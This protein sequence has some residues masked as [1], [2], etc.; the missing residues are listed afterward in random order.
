MSTASDHP[1]PEGSLPQSQPVAADED[2]STKQVTPIGRLT[3]A[4]VA[5]ELSLAMGLMVPLQLVLALHLTRLAD[6]ADATGAFGIVT[7]F[8]ALMGMIANPI[9]GWLSDRSKSRLGRRRTWIMTGALTGALAVVAV[10]F[11]TEV[12]Q[13]VVVWCCVTSLFNFQ[14][15]ATV[16]LLA[17]QVPPKRRGGVS[18]ILGVTMAGGPLIGIVIANTMTAGSPQQWQVLALATIVLAVVAVLLIREKASV[19]SAQAAGGSGGLLAVVKSFWIS[20]RRHPAYW[21]AWLVRFLLTCAIAAPSF[22]AF[23]L[24][25]RFGYSPDEVGGMILQLSGAMIV[26]M[27]ISAIGCGFISDAVKR[28]KPFV[29]AAGIL[30]AAALVGL[31]FATSI[32]VV[33]V[34]FVALGIATGLFSSVDTALCIRMLPNTADAGRDMGMIAN[35][36]GGWLS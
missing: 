27:A 1:T 10:S 24:M 19:V 17:D 31:A 8:G 15:A 9:G 36:I 21:W 26:A 20:P 35:P 11:T 7:G 12:W 2:W 28:Q 30:A 16:G 22:N 6:G 5:S 4:I 14:Y 13:V 25:Q 32:G 29:V 34:V 23:Y 33:Y 3:S 18:G